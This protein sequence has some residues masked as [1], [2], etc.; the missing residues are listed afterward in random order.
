M[1]SRRRQEAR[2][3]VMALAHKQKIVDAVEDF[4]ADVWAHL[5]SV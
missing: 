1:L 3:E 4:P 5:I 2:K